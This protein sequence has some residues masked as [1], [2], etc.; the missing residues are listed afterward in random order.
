MSYKAWYIVCV[1]KFRY[2]RRPMCRVIVYPIN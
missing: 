1:W 2:G